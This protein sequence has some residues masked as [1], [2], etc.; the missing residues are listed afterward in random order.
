MADIPAWNFVGR[1]AFTKKQKE[2]FFERGIILAED[3]K[4]GTEC[5]NRY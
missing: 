1:E 2:I 4:G 3:L 5:P